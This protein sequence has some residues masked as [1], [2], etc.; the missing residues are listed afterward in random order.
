MKNTY[1]TDCQEIQDFIFENLRVFKNELEE[2]E[3]ETLYE[4]NEE[5]ILLEIEES[6]ENDLRLIEIFE[7]VNDI[8]EDLVHIKMISEFEEV[9]E[10]DSLSKEQL[11]YISVNDLKKDKGFDFEKAMFDF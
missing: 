2:D 1:I 4:I 11:K 9:I 7:T 5:V 8:F 3:I 6:E 10:E